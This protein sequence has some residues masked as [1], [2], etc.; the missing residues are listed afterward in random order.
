MQ[1]S[2][3]VTGKSILFFVNDNVNSG[4]ILPPDIIYI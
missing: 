2:N 3:G 1:P 4:C